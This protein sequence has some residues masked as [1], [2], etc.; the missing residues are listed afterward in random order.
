MKRPEAKM[1]EQLTLQGACRTR[2]VVQVALPAISQMKTMTMLSVDPGM[3]DWKTP[4][5]TADTKAVQLPAAAAIT[6]EVTM[7]GVDMVG[8]EEGREYA[9]DEQRI[10]E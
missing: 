5:A 6:V 4:I 1:Q 2:I 7:A 8:A 10:F 3:P 9:N